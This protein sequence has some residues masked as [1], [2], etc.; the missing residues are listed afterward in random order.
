MSILLT[1]CDGYMGWPLI[2]ALAKAFP[3]E[4]IVGNVPYSIRKIHEISSYTRSRIR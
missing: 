4:K 3:D 2:L 1:G